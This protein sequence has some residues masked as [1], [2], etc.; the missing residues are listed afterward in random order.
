MARRLIKMSLKKFSGI[1]SNEVFF[2]LTRRDM[3]IAEV[4]F[5][6]IRPDFEDMPSILNAY[7][8]ACI[9]DE[10]R[11]VNHVFTVEYY[12]R[13]NGKKFLIASVDSERKIW[14]EYYSTLFDDII[15]TYN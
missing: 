6:W 2:F 9:S 3:S 13:D 4:P 10:I 1:P 5:V 8:R 15:M 14:S 7:T 12:R 11:V